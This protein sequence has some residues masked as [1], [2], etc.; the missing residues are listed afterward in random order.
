MHPNKQTVMFKYLLLFSLGFALLNFSS[1]FAQG[2]P[3]AGT[4]TGKVTSIDNQP[5]E[6]VSV[7]LVELNKNTLTDTKGIFVFSGIQAGQYSIRIQ[8]IGQKQTIIP[9][10][11]V[12]GD[13]A[14]ADYHLDKESITAMQEAQVMG[15]KNPYIQQESFYIARL[16]LK[17]LENPQVYNTVSK[18]LFTEQMAVDFGSVGK[19]VPG[20]GVPMIANQGRVTWFSRGFETEPNARNGV[21][22]SAFSDIDPVNLERVEVIKG[23]S[24]TLFGTNIS[25]SY[26]GLFNRVT[27][28]PYNGFGGEVA[29]LGG[30]WDFNRLTFDVNTPINQ[31]RTALFRF[32]GATTFQHSF[33][34][35]GFQNTLALAPSFSYQITDRLSLLLDVEFEQAKA[36]SVVRFNPYTG[37]HKTESIATMGFPYNKTFLS[38]DITY[39][40]QMLNIF[41]QLNYK[42]SDQ[43]QSQTIISRTRSSINGDITALTGK[44]DSTIAPQ[45]INGYTNFIATDLQQNFVGDFHI[46]QFRNRTVIGIDYFHNYNDFDRA[47]INFK[48]TNFIHPVSTYKITQSMVDSAYD[49]GTLRKE[50]NADNTY[51]GYISDVFNLTPNLLVMV[52][53]R[54]DRYHYDGVYNITTSA[55]TG[56]YDQT[57]FSHKSGIVY[58]VL[59]DRLSLFGNYMNGFFNQTGSA[60]DGSTFKPEHANQLEFGVK[61]D[62]FQHKLAGTISYYDIRVKD[63]LRTDLNNPEYDIQD[64]TQLSKGVEFD[65]TANPFRGFNI[66]AG[67]AYNDS[68]YTRADSTVQGLRPA[69]SGPDRMLNF[70]ASYRVPRG[71]WQGFGVG[72]GGNYGSQSYQTNT[73]TM[74]ITIPS[75]TALDATI[76]Y[77]QPKYRIGIK[78]NNLTSEKMWSTRLTPQ[79]PAQFIGTMALKF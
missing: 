15:S 10:A 57:A 71:K 58:E 67:Y 69:G 79:N 28:K 13:T 78:V 20:A 42:I 17:N 45:V 73:K 37:S 51:A 7:T 49:N 33:Q 48:A 4:I 27:K 19:D 39:S 59:P 38:N 8:M 63:V 9:V 75:Y 41:A 21:A 53:G 12:A 62:L 30:S 35:V 60:A 55:V 70:W 36:T 24:T 52:S 2:G 34:D 6:L 44:T 46:G 74:K 14:H 64:G 32:N 61:G 3:N 43:W 66:V 1:T 68:R 31:D 76:F 47:T 77:D 23:P 22:G 26:G 65:L 25:S 56:A 11:V 5:L 50:T 29:Y 40:T 18:E 72:F 54:I 16:P